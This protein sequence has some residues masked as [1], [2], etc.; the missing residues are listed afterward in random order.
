MPNRT[1]K[2]LVNVF[3]FQ[4]SYVF[5]QNTEFLSCTKYYT[6]DF[7]S[8]LFHTVPELNNFK[9]TRGDHQL[10]DKITLN[11]RRRGG[12]MVSAAGLRIERS[13]SSPGRGSALQLCSWARY[14]T[15]IV[16]LYTQ[17][18][19]W[20]PANLLLGITLRWSSITSRGE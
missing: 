17:V 7:F 20:V 6:V 4:L 2:V 3:T 16:P 10:K 8:S 5:R 14:F 9:I 15:L 12:L 1:K 11:L 13:G 19:K 18:Y